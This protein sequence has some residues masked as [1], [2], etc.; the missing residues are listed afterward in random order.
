[1]IVRHTLCSILKDQV[2]AEGGRFGVELVCSSL[3]EMRVE[4][5]SYDHMPEIVTSWSI[6]DTG[7]RV[8]GSVITS[9]IPTCSVVS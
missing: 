9:C 6:Q 3:R 2:I 7:T 8:L 5:V 1:M 4:T